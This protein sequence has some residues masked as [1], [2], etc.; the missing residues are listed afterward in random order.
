MTRH[1]S[2]RKGGTSSAATRREQARQRARR[3]AAAMLAG[4]GASPALIEAVAPVAAAIYDRGYHAG[5]SAAS[6]KRR[7]SA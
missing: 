5:A 2:G 3:L 1:D 7:R 4:R 6:L